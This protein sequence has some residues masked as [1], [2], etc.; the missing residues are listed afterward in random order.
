MSHPFARRCGSLGRWL[1]SYSSRSESRI[2]W[3]HAGQCRP[4]PSNRA[5]K[6]QDGQRRSPTKRSSHCGHSYTV[7]TQPSLTLKLTTRSGSFE[8]GGVRRRSR[9]A[10]CRWA[11]EQ[12]LARASTKESPHN[13]FD[14]AI[15]FYVGQICHP[16]W[17]CARA[18]TTRVNHGASPCTQP[19][20]PSDTTAG[21]RR[22]STVKLA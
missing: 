8:V 2:G 11:G 21:I 5:N 16:K 14:N 20:A 22:Q 1:A 12:N 18:C 3:S 10:S 4:K 15:S 9:Y 19:A 17:V 13:H 6:W 7:R